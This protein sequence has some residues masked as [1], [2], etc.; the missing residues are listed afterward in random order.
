MWKEDGTRL[1]CI[2][3]QWHK[4]K[5]SEK[6]EWWICIQQLASCHTNINNVGNESHLQTL[7][8]DGNAVNQS[9]SLIG[10]FKGWPWEVV[11]FPGFLVYELKWVKK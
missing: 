2:T 10:I 3:I 9:R 4:C 11:I 6:L 5:W 7:H 8:G 1:L